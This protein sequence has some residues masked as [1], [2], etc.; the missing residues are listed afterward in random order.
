VSTSSDK[1]VGGCFIIEFG[2][3][4]SAADHDTAV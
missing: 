4:A 1:N 3:F 2:V